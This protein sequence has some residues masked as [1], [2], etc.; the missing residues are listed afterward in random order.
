MKRGRFGA[1]RN[2][3]RVQAAFRKQLF[4]DGDELYQDMIESIAGA[5]RS[6]SLETYTF[7]DDAVGRRFVQTLAERAERGVRV[8]MLVDAVGSLGSFS[9]ATEKL[10][11]RAGVRVRRFHRWQWRTPLRYNRRDHRKLLVVDQRLA[12]LGGFNIDA[13]N[14]RR[15]VGN[16]CWRDTHL[17]LG[18]ALAR[19]AQASFDIFWYRRWD[20][21]QPVPMPAHDMLVSNHNPYARRRLRVFIEDMMANAR[22]RLW[23]TSPYFVP[24]RGMQQRLINAA[25]RGADVRVLVPAKSDVPLARWASHAAYATL[26]AAGVQ[27]YEYL[28]RMLHSKTLL[29]DRDW[30]MVGTSNFDYRSFRHNYELNLLSADPALCDQLEEHFLMDLTHSRQVLHT[31]WQQRSSW[32]RIGEAI[33][34]A[35]RRWL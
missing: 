2:D 6:I 18:G 21:H 15:V 12:W 24:D 10:L 7:R 31:R 13:R 29:V 32:Q 33:G 35:A 3:S 5:R 17:R 8:R 23:V 26:L 34:W 25:G 19:D 16:A 27:V 28:P 30:S 1:E 11:L 14:S 20:W 22:H 9:Q 4:V